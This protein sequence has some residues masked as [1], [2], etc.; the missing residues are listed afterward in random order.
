MF[1]WTRLSAARA[2]PLR[3]KMTAMLIVVALVVLI[4]ACFAFVAYDRHSTLAQKGHTA[5]VLASIIGHTLAGPVA[6]RDRS[7]SELV[8]SKLAGEPTAQVAAIYV[9]DQG[10]LATWAVDPGVAAP[11]DLASARAHSPGG[12]VAVVRPI[13]GPQGPIGHLY[14]Q[15]GTSD[16]EERLHQFLAITTAVG[17]GSLLLAFIMAAPLRRIVTDPVESLASVAHR[18][19]EQQDYSARVPTLGS[20]ELGQL[21]AAFNAMLAGIEQRDADLLRHQGQL[22]GLVEARTRALAARNA[23]MSLV[24]DNV[25]QGFVTLNGQGRLSEECSAIF[26]SWFGRYHT[27]APPTLGELLSPHDPAFGEM[28]RLGWEFML[29]GFMPQ[30]VCIA[31]LPGQVVVDGRHLTVAYKAL[32]T[33]GGL[34]VLVVLTDVTAQLEAAHAAATQAEL[35]AAFRAAREDRAGLESF[36]AEGQATLDLVRDEHSDAVVAHRAVHTLKGNAGLLELAT[37]PSICHRLEEAY[38]EHEVPSQLLLA[39]FAAAWAAYDQRVRSMLAPCPA[40]SLTAAELRSL[41]NAARGTSA[42]PVLDAL[43]APRA[44]ERLVALGRRA[45]RLARQQGIDV[46]IEVAGGQATLPNQLDESVWA[47]MSHLVRNALVHGIESP[48]VRAAAGKSTTAGIRIAA[49]SAVWSGAAPHQHVVGDAPPLGQELFWVEVA[50]DGC[51]IQWTSL[52]KA[53]IAKQLPH[54]TS[55]DLVAA[56]FADGV[57]SAEEAT[58]LAGRGVGTSA[59]AAA[60]HAAG[61]CVLV[62]SSEG[63]GTGIRVV[64]PRALSAARRAS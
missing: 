17:V 29:D 39:E 11:E 4:V 59:V 60:A 14:L 56:M 16:V 10:L 40:L 22:E 25:E 47:S 51:G 24:M 1:S 28:F 2:V 34:T 9:E 31:Q 61:G 7:S 64:V 23:A 46:A 62:T 27:D 63:C 20:D 19:R 55:A 42:Q 13:D 50:D 58:E 12:A 38:A 43:M 53:A 32:D 6:F 45:K 49:G 18:V 26:R 57:S 36:L 8:L 48:D 54:E 33:P 44:Q 3:A 35:V 30:E 15:L 52:R 21:A 37:V 41:E 5:D